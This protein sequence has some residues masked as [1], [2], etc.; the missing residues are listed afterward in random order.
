[1]L[2]LR[3]RVLRLGNIHIWVV[4]PFYVVDLQMFNKCVLN[5]K[6]VQIWTVPNCSGVD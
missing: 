3:N 1:M 4:P 2:I 5:L 6:N